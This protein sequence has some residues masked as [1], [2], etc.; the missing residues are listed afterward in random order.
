MD[1]MRQQTAEALLHATEAG[2]EVTDLGGRVSMDI[3]ELAETH[4]AS[5][6]EILQELVIHERGVSSFIENC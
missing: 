1:W 3:G 6:D 2:E 4:H 5:V